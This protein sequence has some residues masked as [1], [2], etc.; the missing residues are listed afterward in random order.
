MLGVRP[1]SKHRLCG[2]LEQEIVDH[3]LVVVGDVADRRRHREDD[4]ESGNRTPAAVRPRAPPSRARTIVSSIGSSVVL[5]GPRIFSS[6]SLRVMPYVLEERARE[7]AAAGR[8]GF[9]K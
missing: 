4:V 6:A 1:D 3:R 8:Q 5:T 7:N 2:S 9:S